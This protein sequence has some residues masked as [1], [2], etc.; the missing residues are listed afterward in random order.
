MFLTIHE[1]GIELQLIEYEDFITLMNLLGC[2][3]TNQ[4]YFG[5]WPAYE[6]PN[7]ETVDLSY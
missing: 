2:H 3:Q 5:G 1:L 7:G 4:V 6:F